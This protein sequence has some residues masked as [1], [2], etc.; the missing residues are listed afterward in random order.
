MKPLQ[1]TPIPGNMEAER[2]D[3]AIRQAFS[4]PKEEIQRRE[5]E[6][7]KAQANKPSK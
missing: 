2:F 4:V 3:N 1:A 5:A 7:Q 6:R